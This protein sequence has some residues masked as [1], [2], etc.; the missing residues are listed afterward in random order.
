M[1]NSGRDG[2]K[3]NYLR[4]GKRFITGTVSQPSQ[5]VITEVERSAKRKTKINIIITRKI[6]RTNLS[7]S[8]ILED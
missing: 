8:S 5:V 4:A 1:I 6:S 7:R 2:E 3:S